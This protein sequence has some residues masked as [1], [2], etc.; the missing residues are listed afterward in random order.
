MTVSEIK[1]MEV[2]LS[3]ILNELSM[4]LMEPHHLQEDS[5]M[6]LKVI[7]A[8]LRP[9]SGC[10]SPTLLLIFMYFQSIHIQSEPEI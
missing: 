4:L 10:E 6:N 2:F 9:K 1:L 8:H 5:L 3:L 7:R